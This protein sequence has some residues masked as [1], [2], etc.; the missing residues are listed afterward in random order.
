MPYK[1][2]H[3]F[4]G[5][6][7]LVTL[8]GFWPSY[9]TLVGKVPF[10]FHVHA[11]TALSWLTL[12]IV[13]SVAIH[14][15]HNAFHKLLGKASFVMFPLLIVGFVMIINVSAARFAAQESPFI[16][17]LGPSFGIGMAIAIAAYLTLF[18]LALRNRRNVRLHA[19]YMLATP[20]ILFESPF[21]R[22]MD[23]A[24]P[25][26]NVIGSEGPRQV[27]DTIVVSDTMVAIFAMGLYFMDRKN[28]APWLVATFFVLLQAVAMWF[29]PDIDGLGQFFS[30]YSQVPPGL[31]ILSGL[32]VGG[33]A[34]YLG[35][36]AGGSPAGPVAKTLPT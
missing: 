4:V 31:T 19:G 14:R 6:V 23:Q 8:A 12:L 2:G 36:T 18:Y 16:A 29:A 17:L 26:M 28:G 15:R 20:M 13:Q 35:W 5:F 30:A 3:Y 25:W 34:G 9:F 1:Y 32:L 11:V 24:F 21:S 27:L 7:L 10:A 22:L 33:L